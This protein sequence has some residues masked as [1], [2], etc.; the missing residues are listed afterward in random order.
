[1][2]PKEAACATPDFTREHDGSP[3]VFSE[4]RG[5]GRAPEDPRSALRRRPAARLH[6]R[7]GDRPEKEPSAARRHPRVSR[8]TR[9]LGQRRRPH[10]E[11]YPPPSEANVGV[12]NV[13]GGAGPRF[14]REPSAGASSRF[15][16]VT[17]RSTRNRPRS[18]SPKT[19]RLVRIHPDESTARGARTVRR[20][21]V[22]PLQ[23]TLR[24]RRDAAVSNT[25]TILVSGADGAR[26]G[27]Y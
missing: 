11:K 14:P 23:L 3:A 20:R 16:S 18:L 15:T 5:G 17:G 7:P 2:C 4:R 26:V 8:E 19:R 13:A 6:R 27:A 21:P 9:V 24:S 25:P 1:M 22:Q 10:F 12:R